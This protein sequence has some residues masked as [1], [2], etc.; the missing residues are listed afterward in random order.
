MASHLNI[1][2]FLRPGDACHFHRSRLVAMQQ[3]FHDHNFCE[4]FWIEEGEGVELV[5]EAQPARTE[6]RPGVAALVAPEDA[7]ALG[8]ASRDGCILAN[9]AFR[10][11]FW[12]DLHGRFF[13]GQTDPFATQARRRFD[14]GGAAVPT[15]NAAIQEIEFGD[16]RSAATARFLLNF[17]Y[18]VRTEGA[19]EGR[20]LPRW[21]AELVDSL[22]DPAH[23]REGTTGLVARSGRSAEHVARECRR[24]YGRTPTD[25]V[26]DAR[27]SWASRRLASG[28]ATPLEVSLDCG[29]ANLGHF[30]RLFRARMGDSPSRWASR[31]RTIL[32]P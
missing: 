30:Y 31:Q 4:L 28:D 3:V 12:A 5:G 14:L 11:D 27:I 32:H 20:A 29:F 18:L 16:R 8:G 21:L 22:A 17:M 24:W 19:R 7:H 6:L 25:L 15:L 2:T 26:N 10:R 1:D 9:V 13:P 23:A